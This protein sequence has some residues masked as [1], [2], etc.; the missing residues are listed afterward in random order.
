MTL[1]NITLNSNLMSPATLATVV[2]PAPAVSPVNE[3]LMNNNADDSAGSYAL[4]PVGSPEFV[5][6]A[7]EGSHSLDSTNGS[8]EGSTAY[9]NHPGALTIDL[10]TKAFS[11]DYGE[12]GLIGKYRFGNNTRSWYITMRRDGVVNFSV[13]DNGKSVPSRSSVRTAPIPLDTWVRITAV[14]SPNQY[15]R[16]YIDGA[17]AAE[18]TDSVPA[19]TFA[20]SIGLLIG[21]LRD[22]NGSPVDPYPGLID[23]VRIYNQEVLP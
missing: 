6:D 15:Q 18:N 9:T 11:F 8:L 5:A 16:V 1:L 3:F 17:L 14:L 19:N 12:K 21:T 20:S 13:S 4:A 23:R 22:G 10:Y 7:V 2:P